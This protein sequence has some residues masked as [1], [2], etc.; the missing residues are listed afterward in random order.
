MAETFLPD[1][2]GVIG[3]ISQERRKEILHALG[4]TRCRS[5]GGSKKPK[6]SHCRKC[7]FALPPNMRHALYNGFGDG[8]EEA[9]EA[10]LEFLAARSL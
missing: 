8:Y 5:C 1:E 7:Y 9:Y 2:N 3:T 4:D 10:S 6:M